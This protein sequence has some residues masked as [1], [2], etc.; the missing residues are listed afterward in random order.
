MAHCRG[1]KISQ[2]VCPRFQIIQIE[3]TFCQSAKEAGH[4]VLK[5]FAARTEQGSV[6]VKLA[7]KWYEIALVSTGSM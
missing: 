5:N 3:H 4:S 2:F 1:D 6:R 7:S